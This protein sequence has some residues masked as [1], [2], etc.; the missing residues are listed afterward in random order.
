M[1]D[2]FRGSIYDNIGTV[3]KESARNEIESS[4]TFIVYWLG[5]III[6]GQNGYRAHHLFRIYIT[7]SF[8]ICQRLSGLGGASPRD[9]A[10]GEEW[11]DDRLWPGI[12][13]HRPPS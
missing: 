13:S 1:I 7:S 4:L 12:R 8:T 2:S 3:K 9:R 6:D 10:E 11:A 5:D